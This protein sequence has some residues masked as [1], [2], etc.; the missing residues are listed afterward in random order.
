M[1]T[2]LRRGLQRPSHLKAAVTS[3][4]RPRLAAACLGSA[5]C[6]ATAALAAPSKLAQV[7]E[8]ELEAYVQSLLRSGDFHANG[9]PDAIEKAIYTNVTRLTINSLLWAVAKLDGLTFLG[10]ELTL[11]ARATSSGIVS[12]GR[13]ERDP[14][15]LEAVVGRLLANQSINQTWLPDALEAR[16]YTNVLRVFFTVLDDCVSAISLNLVGHELLLDLRARRGAAWLASDAR[17]VDEAVVRRLTEDLLADPRANI[18]WLPDEVERQL[19]ANTFRLVLGLL[20]EILGSTSLR[21]GGREVVLHLRPTASSSATPSG[22]GTER[23]HHAA[24]TPAGGQQ[25]AVAALIAELGAL[26]EEERAAATAHEAELEQLRRR[27][28]VVKRAL[29]ACGSTSR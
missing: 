22:D 20:Q 28:D 10:M 3:L 9:I 25:P 27:K 2:T 8:G 14:A 15:L 5:A 23:R 7:D 12:S 17:P 13:A 26:R 29:R 21:C 18:G 4:Q 16:L 24:A 11:E 19:Y 1:L 6:C